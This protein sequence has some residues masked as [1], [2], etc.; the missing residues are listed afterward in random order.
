M[1]TKYS[2]MNT[3][4][5]YKWE[6][7]LKYTSLGHR[8]DQDELIITHCSLGGENHLKPILQQIFMSR[9]NQKR[10]PLITHMLS[11]L[12]QNRFFEQAST[13]NMYQEQSWM[14]CIAPPSGQR[15]MILVTLWS[16]FCQCFIRSAWALQRIYS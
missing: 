16:V 6:I 15:N 3:I 2:M 13:L 14:N 11:S 5:R 4:R 8:Q 12:P 7:T 1:N 9:S 10:F